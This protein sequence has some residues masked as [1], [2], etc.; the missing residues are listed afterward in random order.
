MAANPASRFGGSS[1]E[2]SLKY[3]R[4]LA[5]TALNS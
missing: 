4:G 1:A 5:A 2:A 3:T